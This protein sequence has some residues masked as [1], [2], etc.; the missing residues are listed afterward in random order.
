M[1]TCFMCKGTLQDGT[2]NFTADF[3][4][5]IVIVRNVPSCICS[6][7]GEVSYNEETAKRLE[8]IVHSLTEPVKTEIAVVSYTERAA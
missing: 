1:M 2:S 6:Q 5:C 3:N 4:K 8:D 7:C